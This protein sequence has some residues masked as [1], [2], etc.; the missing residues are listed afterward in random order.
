[1]QEKIKEYGQDI[2]EEAEKTNGFGKVERE[3]LRNLSRASKYGFEKLMKKNKLDALVTP[4]DN[5]VYVLS[6][7]GYPGINV[8]AGYNSQGI[9]FGIYFG[10]LKGSEPRL[11][12]IAYDF[13]RSTMIRK[14]PPLHS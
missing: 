3:L 8:P 5:I 1:M 10:G 2:F 6:V 7:G 14:P 13:E 4:A 12:E 11:I 9:P